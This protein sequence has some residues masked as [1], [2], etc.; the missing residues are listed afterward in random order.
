[1][2][3]AEKI[4][5]LFNGIDTEQVSSLAGK[6]SED[7]NYG[8]FRFRASNHWIDG[9]RSRTSFKNFYAGGKENTDRKTTLTVDADQPAFLAGENTA[10]NAV[11]HLLHALNSCLSTTLVYHASVNGVPLDAVEV[12]SEGEMNARGF[13]GIS[14]AVSK[15]Y[16]R[17]KVNMEVK[18]NADVET[19]TKLAMHS[20]VYEMVSKAVPVDF[21]LTKS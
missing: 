16:E 14:D 8:K 12:S 20:P 10:P 17:I 19:L 4:T 2:N 3:T 9:S 1:M 13:F 6:I 18:S 11:E 21:S 7:E 15:G 5:P